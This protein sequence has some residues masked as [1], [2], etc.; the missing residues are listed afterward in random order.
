MMASIE[1]IVLSVSA[2]GSE[3]KRH[4]HRGELRVVG[5]GIFAKWPVLR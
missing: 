5:E 4:M 3:Q 1:S 2:S